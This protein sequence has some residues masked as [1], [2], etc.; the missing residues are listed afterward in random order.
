MQNINNLTGWRTNPQ[1]IS[2]C[3]NGTIVV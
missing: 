2:T 1:Q 3:D